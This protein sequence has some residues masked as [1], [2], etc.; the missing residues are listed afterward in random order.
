MADIKLT[1]K[2]ALTT[3]ASG[4]VLHIVDVSDTT[5]DPA[6]TSK[7]ITH[8][9]LLSGTTKNTDTD[10]SSN[11]YFLDEDDLN[12]D[13]ATKVASQQSI[14][15][16]ADTKV[17]KLSSVTDNRL[18]KNDG[19]DG[20]I[21]QTGISV[22]DSDNVSG[23]NSIT[24][25]DEGFQTG[26]AIDTI[27]VDGSS[28]DV[29]LKVEQD[30]A[31]NTAQIANIKHVDSADACPRFFSLKSRGSK[32][33][34][35]ILQDGD[36]VSC[37]VVA[38]YD[39]TDYQPTAI[40]RSQI[41]DSVPGMGGMTADLSF[42]VSTSATTEEVL[43]LDKDKIA[44]FA[45]GVKLNDS[46]FIASEILALDSSKNVQTLPV[47]TYPSLAELA[48]VKGATSAI[49]T[50]IDS[51]AA[52]AASST[53]NTIPRFDGTTGKILQSSSVVI[54]DSD[55]ISG[56]DKLTV[57]SIV[58]N[59]SD[60]ESTGTSL[61]LKAAT[62]IRVF[63]DM[64]FAIGKSILDSSNLEILKFSGIT[65]AVNEITIQNAATGNAPEL[66]ATGDD[67]NVDLVLT[68]KGTGEVKVGANAVVDAGDI[69]NSVQ[70][71]DLVLDEV[72]AQTII[73]E[74]TTSRTLALTDANDYIRTTNASAT[75][76]TVPTNASVAFPIGTQIDVFQAGAGQVDFAASGGVTINYNTG[77]KIANQYQA[78][79]LK[80]VATDEWD[81][82]GALGA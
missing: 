17:T 40:I 78:A 42:H 51:K 24:I 34:P 1:N 65:S 22:D 59:D 79:T 82:I 14:K 5:S 69:G 50:Q 44:H 37:W 28:Y 16:Y 39:G 31:G 49:Q 62:R 33:S 48:Y 45:G 57:N 36:I 25:D 20:D 9:N 60:V 76:I 43:K 74:S 19:T 54:N 55:E 73:T 29:R 3:P 46:S 30:G 56:I 4:D 77:L 52:G 7:K 71:Y 47:A 80:K 26:D 75:T 58:I 18:I 67:T 8:T 32:A 27:T 10:L 15:A 53:D 23:L 72:A 2:T 61:N 41:N 11:N 35:A 68:P 38:G 13:D 66:Q 12:S 63:E 6:G 70:A 64:G 21:Q 81:L